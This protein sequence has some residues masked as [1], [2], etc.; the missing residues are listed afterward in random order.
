M[1]L[2]WIV[3][4]MMV[5]L[6]CKCSTLVSCLSLRTYTRALSSDVSSAEEEKPWN[7]ANPQTGVENRLNVTEFGKMAKTLTNNRT[8]EAILKLVDFY[9]DISQKEEALKAEMKSMKSKQSETLQKMQDIHRTVQADRRTELSNFQL[10]LDR[11]A[12]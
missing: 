10:S 6:L 1:S 4:A 2:S 9:K 5:I 7:E 8:S 3:P 12:V 11:S